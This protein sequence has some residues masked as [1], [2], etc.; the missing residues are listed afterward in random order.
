VK[1]AD[2]DADLRAGRLAAPPPLPSD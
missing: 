1:I 2:L